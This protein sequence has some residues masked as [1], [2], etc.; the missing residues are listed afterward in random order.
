[1]KTNKIR[2]DDHCKHPLMM[3]LNL[4]KSQAPSSRKIQAGVYMIGLLDKT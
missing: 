4:I 1:M 2:F 3:V